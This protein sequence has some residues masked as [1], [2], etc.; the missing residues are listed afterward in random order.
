[1]NMLFLTVTLFYILISKFL[2]VV[3]QGY[4]EFILLVLVTYVVLCRVLEITLI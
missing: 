2:K 4:N 3:L 1:M